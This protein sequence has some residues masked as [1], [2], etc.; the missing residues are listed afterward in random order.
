MLQSSRTAAAALALLGGLVHAQGLPST[1]RPATEGSWPRL[2]LSDDLVAGIPH[3]SP[4]QLQAPVATKQAPPTSLAQLA[5][6]AL[7]NQPALRAAQARASVDDDRVEQARSALRPT[8]RGS[9]GNQQAFER[10]SNVAPARTQLGGMQG[11][12]PLYR[13]QAYASIDAATSHLDATRAQIIETEIELLA[14]LIAAY[15][16]AAQHSDETRT[17]LAEQYLLLAQRQTNQRRVTSGTG[18]VAEV[19][20]TS[21]RADLIAVKVRDSENADTKQLAELNRISVTPVI[22]VLPMRDE[23]PRLLVPKNAQTAFDSARA[24]NPT[25]L[26]LRM[27]LESARAAISSQRDA[28]LPRVDMIARVNRSGAQF[29]GIATQIPSTAVGLQLSVPLHDEGATQS[30]LR[31][32]QILASRTEDQLHGTESALQANIAKAYENMDRALARL[33]TNVRALGIAQAALDTTLKAFG[34]GAHRNI[35]VLNALQRMSS[36]KHDLIRSRTEI[37]LAQTRILSLI[38]NLNL[39]TVGQLAQSLA[40]GA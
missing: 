12:I 2:R 10:A 26:R 16:T 21:A 6:N 36:I 17:L 1:P 27:T 14:A 37:Q 33:A 24:Q 13:P 40:S 39:E 22:A 18:T 31:A 34:A 25:L 30:Q 35:D 5:M 4:P 20:E 7:L 9:A 8:V 32:A 3:A 29:D 15:F 38:G 28:H 19:L 11:T 23:T